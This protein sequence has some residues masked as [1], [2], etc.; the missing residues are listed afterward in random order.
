MNPD[1]KNI[2]DDSTAN[3]AW[4]EIYSFLDKNLGE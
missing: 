2:Y 1:N 4:D 3:K